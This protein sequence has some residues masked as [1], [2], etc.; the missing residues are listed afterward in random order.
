MDGWNA[1]LDEIQMRFE[2]GWRRLMLILDAE[3]CGK[4]CAQYLERDFTVAI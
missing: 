2:D 4:V 1:C 3:Y